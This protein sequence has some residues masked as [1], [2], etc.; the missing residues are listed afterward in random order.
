MIARP[1]PARARALWLAALLLLLAGAGCAAAGEAGPAAAPTGEPSHRGDSALSSYRSTR[2]YAETATPVRLR[3]PVIGVD[4]G[5]E[6]L[7]RAPDQTIEVPGEPG[8]AGWW[9]GGPRPGQ[10]GPAVLLGHVDSRTGPAVF[11]RLHELTAG[12]EVLIDRAHADGAA[13]G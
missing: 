9:S 5:L 7:G 10:V 13:A 6:A 8:T 1:R 12:D 3:I 2:T 4:S 11:F